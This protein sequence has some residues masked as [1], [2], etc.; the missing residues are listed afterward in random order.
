MIK[1]SQ[2]NPLAPGGGVAQY[3]FGEFSDWPL[4][5]L[6][7]LLDSGSSVIGRLPPF[8]L[9][10]CYGDPLTSEVIFRFE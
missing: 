6:P 1:I 7:Y 10:L 8:Q 9:V 5:P 4:C 2:K 3:R